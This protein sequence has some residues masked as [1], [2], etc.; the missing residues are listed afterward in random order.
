MPSVLGVSSPSGMAVIV[1]RPV[2]RAKRKA[3]KKNRQ[4]ADQHAD[5][6]A[7]HHVAKCDLGRKFKDDRPAG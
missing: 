7:R 5:G 3:N 1:L 6:R 2:S 4:I